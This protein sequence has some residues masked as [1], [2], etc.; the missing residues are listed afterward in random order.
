MTNFW[1]ISWCHSRICSYDLDG[2]L[3]PL[4]LI[5]GHLFTENL[6]SKLRHN[7][8]KFLCPRPIIAD[9]STHRLQVE[10][11]QP[12][13]NFFVAFA[14][15]AFQV[16]AIV[17]KVALDRLSLPLSPR[18]IVV[19]PSIVIGKINVILCG[20]FLEY[21]DCL[22][23]RDARTYYL[24]PNELT[25]NLRKACSHFFGSQPY[26]LGLNTCIGFTIR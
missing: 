17:N 22:S 9:N 8:Q 26:R 2:P 21:L 5:N 3:H 11:S 7:H 12:L 15:S 4:E 23:F 14:L 24:L 19:P 16:P 10:V 1:N 13:N 20:L 18:R 6:L 25:R